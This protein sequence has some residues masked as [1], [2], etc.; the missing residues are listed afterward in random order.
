M[1]GTLDLSALNKSS[2]RVGTFL[3][4]VAAGRVGSYTYNQK[5]DNRQVT[6][7]KFEAYFMG[8]KAETYCLGIFKVQRR[9]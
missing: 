1:A 5:K 8:K 4:K 6:Q 9:T 3:V 2:S 7:H